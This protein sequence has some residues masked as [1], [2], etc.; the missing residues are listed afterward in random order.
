[1]VQCSS[2]RLSSILPA[3]FSGLAANDTPVSSLLV[4]FNATT[5]PNATPPVKVV[6]A[7]NLDGVDIE[8]TDP[9]LTV[10]SFE[11]TMTG[12]GVNLLFQAF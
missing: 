10:S 9:G 1:M 6:S 4:L 8:L 5:D 12:A 11:S 3:L 2:A 7:I